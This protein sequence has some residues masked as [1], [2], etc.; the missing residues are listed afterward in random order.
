MNNTYW[1]FEGSPDLEPA[2][3]LRQL[4]LTLVVAYCIYAYVQRRREY[5]VC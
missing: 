5:Q 2:L 3:N 1:F 4:L